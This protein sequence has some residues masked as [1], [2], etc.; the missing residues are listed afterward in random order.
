M[1]YLL[2]FFL[3]S[4]Q[5]SYVAANN[6]DI[7]KLCNQ[8]YSEDYKKSR[9]LQKATSKKIAK[10]YD[11]IGAKD[12]RGLAS[13]NIGQAIEILKDIEKSK[14]SLKS[15]DRSILW[16]SWAYIYFV[17]KN[18]ESAIYMYD[19]VISEDEVTLPVRNEAIKACNL[20]KK[21]L[22]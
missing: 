21:L 14:D 3:L 18:W 12:S 22:E 9:K 6:Y 10:F 13:P 7:S 16:N 15:Y 11:A 8:S 2:S 4:I 20:I 1:K 5:V 19:K 17:E